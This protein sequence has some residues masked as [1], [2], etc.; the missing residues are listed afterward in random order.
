MGVTLRMGY[1]VVLGTY[2][3]IAKGDVEN[4]VL[5]INNDDIKPK[6]IEIVP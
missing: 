2:Y 6:A 4:A 3:I 1:S 5:E